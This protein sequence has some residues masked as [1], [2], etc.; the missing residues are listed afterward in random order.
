MSQI[1]NQLQGS[2]MIIQITYLLENVAETISIQN[3]Q[4]AGRAIQALIEL[5]AGNFTNQE[6][7]FRGQ[8]LASINMFLKLDPM[9][10]EKAS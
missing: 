7:A 1:F 3:L 6:V 10:F 8:A 9:S 5:C 2:C 4:I